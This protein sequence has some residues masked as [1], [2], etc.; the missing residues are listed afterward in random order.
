MKTSYFANI[1]FIDTDIYLPVSISVYAPDWYSGIEF[2]QL[3]PTESILKRYKRGLITVEQYTNEFNEQVLAKYNP[4]VLYAKLVGIKK[5]REPILLCYEKPNQFC[6][7]H[8]VAA[9]FN[10]SGKF[11]EEL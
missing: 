11:V 4:D 3:S 5:N 10:Q 6:H 7:R 8:L 1:P 9:W 2:H